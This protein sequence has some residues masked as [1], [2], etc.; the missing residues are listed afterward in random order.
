MTLLAAY[1]ATETVLEL[2]IA[3]VI[4]RKRKILVQMARRF[5][6]DATGTSAVMANQTTIRNMI[7]ALPQPTENTEKYARE[8]GDTT[9]DKVDRYNAACAKARKDHKKLPNYADFS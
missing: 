3:V 1:I 4:Y 7:A 2:A 8:A 9:D 5:I 6:F